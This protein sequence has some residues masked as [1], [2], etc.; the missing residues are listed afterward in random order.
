MWVSLTLRNGS[1]KMD[2]REHATT[3]ELLE[4]WDWLQGTDYNNKWFKSLAK[5]FNGARG[6]LDSTH[7]FPRLQDLLHSVSAKWDRRFDS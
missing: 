6:F 5:L 4:F 1:F 3:F 2:N 7:M